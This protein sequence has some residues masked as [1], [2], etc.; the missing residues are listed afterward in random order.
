MAKT[1]MS[2]NDSPMH[3]DAD[4]ATENVTESTTGDESSVTEGK[5]ALMKDLPQ[6]EPPSAG[7][8]VQLFV[9][10]ALIVMAVLGV[11]LLFGQLAT[12]ELDWRRAVANIKS[13]N[14]HIRWCA[15]MTLSEMLDADHARGDEGQHLAQNVEIA[16]AISDIYA[17]FLTRQQFTDE[18]REQMEFL[19]KAIGRLDVP[20]VVN[21]VLLQAMQHND[22]D[23]QRQSLVAASMIAG[24]STE[25]RP[26]DNADVIEAALDMSFSETSMIRQSAVYFL[27][28]V[29]SEEAQRRLAALL[30]HGD[31]ITQINAAIGLARSG[32]TEGLV[33]FEKAVDGAISDPPRDPGARRPWR[34]RIPICKSCSFSTTRSRRSNYSR[35]HSARTREPRGPTG[36]SDWP[37][38]ATTR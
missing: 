12:G 28:L 1:E 30:D 23:I 18:E 3:D 6:V 13:E 32:S 17:N 24:E 22:E 34:Y 31:R 25:G 20:E 2:P 14:P 9:V 26:Y 27:G 36:C 38:S 35:N 8:I 29:E 16:H 4:D 33:V 11:W 10:P 5:P 19:S 21:P 37:T 15:A 7:F